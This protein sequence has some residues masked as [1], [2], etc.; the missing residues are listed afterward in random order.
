[1][2]CGMKQGYDGLGIC[3]DVENRKA[4]SKLGSG[5]LLGRCAADVNP[6]CSVQGKCRVSSSVRQL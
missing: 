4:G 6:G 2:F 5:Q 1:M 3:W